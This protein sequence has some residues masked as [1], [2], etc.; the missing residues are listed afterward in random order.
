[1][2]LARS[3]A[4]EKRVARWGGRSQS[5]ALSRRCGGVR[6][7]RTRKRFKNGGMAGMPHTFWTVMKGQRSASDTTDGSARAKAE[8]GKRRAMSTQ[9]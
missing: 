9:Q 7:K 8:E 6:R 3:P 5:R 2:A 1:M 4:L